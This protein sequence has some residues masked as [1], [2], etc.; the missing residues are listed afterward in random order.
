MYEILN[1]CSLTNDAI[2]WRLG[3]E[4]LYW[5]FVIIVVPFNFF[6]FSLV[7]SFEIWANWFWIKIV[8][9]EVD[10]MIWSR[11][12]GNKNLPEIIPY[13]MFLENI[14]MLRQKKGVRE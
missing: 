7:L 5:P 3:E 2:C 6:A 11:K 14:H 8:R 12:S 9:Y 4:S 10:I 1:E 13:I